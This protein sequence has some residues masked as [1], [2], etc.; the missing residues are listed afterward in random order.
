MEKTLVLSIVCSKCK[1][2]DEKRFKE[3][4]SIEI[5]K[6][7]VQLKIYHYLKNMSQHFRLK[8]IDKPRNYFLEEREQNEFMS[9]NHKKV[10]AILNYI[11][12]F[13]I[14]NSA[15]TGFISISMYSKYYS[16]VW[17]V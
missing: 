10:C 2:E 15:I 1:N 8:K 12:H 5:L 14:L 9:S 7:L 3:E 6:I 16:I 17:S 11:E 13:P 4:E